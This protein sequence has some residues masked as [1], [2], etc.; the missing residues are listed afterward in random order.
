MSH[1]YDAQL[2]KYFARLEIVKTNINKTG[3]TSKENAIK[4]MAEKQQA[5]KNYAAKLRSELGLAK[6][7]VIIDEIVAKAKN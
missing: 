6:A 3:Y 4:I 5:V 7:Q 1:C 2:K